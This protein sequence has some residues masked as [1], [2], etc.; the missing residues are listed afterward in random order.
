MY[1]AEFYNSFKS[2]LKRVKKRDCDM[3]LLEKI[4]DKLI[5]GNTLEP[6]YRDHALTGEYKGYRECHIKPDWL[7]V[8]GISDRTI[9]FFRTGTHADLF[10]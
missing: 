5:N 6:R 8:Y 10:K 9:Y 2:D 3:L 4:M 1:K 7:L